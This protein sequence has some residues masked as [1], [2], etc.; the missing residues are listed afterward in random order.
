MTHRI[1]FTTC[2]H[3]GKRAYSTRKHARQ[4]RHQGNHTYPCPHLDG[5]W[6]NGHFKPEVLRGEIARDEFYGPNG[7]GRI[8]YAS[9][10]RRLGD[11]AA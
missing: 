5:K 4:V 10:A 2:E 6:H 7:R 8:R 1:P 9:P 3:C 11:A